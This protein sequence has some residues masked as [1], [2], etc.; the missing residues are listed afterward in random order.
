MPRAYIIA[1]RAI[2]YRKKYRPLRKER[3]SLKQSP[4]CL[5]TK[6]TLFRVK[7]LQKRCLQKV[8]KQTRTRKR[9]AV[10]KSA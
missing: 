10:N 8:M 7:K 5:L 6:G 3:V 9:S 4:F 2:S 1:R